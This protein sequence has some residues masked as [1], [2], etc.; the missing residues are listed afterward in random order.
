MGMIELLPY[1][2]NLWKT[3]QAEI[4]DSAK[5]IEYILKSRRNDLGTNQIKI[6]IL[7]SAFEQLARSF[8]ENNGGFGDA[9]KF[10]SPHTLLFLL[11]YW[12]R[13]LL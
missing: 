3:K 1:I 6:E 2:D 9:P 12:K 13:S 11:R 8:D 10:P 4:K 5:E 7:D